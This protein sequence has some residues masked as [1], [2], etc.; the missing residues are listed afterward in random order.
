MTSFKY[1]DRKADNVTVLLPGWATD[2]RI[3][4]SLN[5]KSDLIVPLEMSPYDFEKSLFNVLQKN[6]KPVS[7][8]GFSMGGFMAARFASENPGLIDRLTLVG[9]RA[10]YNH[11]EIEKIKRY[12]I[13]NKK[14]YLYSFFSS[15][16]SGKKEM[17]RFKSELLKSYC[18]K[19]DLDYL[20]KT[21]DYLGR[22]A[23]NPCMLARV[24]N[25]KI[26]HGERDSIAPIDEARAIK[27]GSPRAEFV[28]IKGAGHI[29][30]F[31]EEKSKVL[32]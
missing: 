12:L 13:K 15:A 2:C 27:E 24:K 30:F 7:I 26:I 17:R 8:F 31:S 18:D 19:F 6:D 11:E 21:L 29:P 22:C 28:E 4:A 1:I 10:R 5:F 14:A 3:F 23:I 9:I 16:F 32:W 20:L 25:V